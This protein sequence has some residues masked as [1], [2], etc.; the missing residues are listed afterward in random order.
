M[1]KPSPERQALVMKAVNSSPYY[2]HV[3]MAIVA[4]VETGSKLEM[5]VKQE[6]LN[7]W[8]T[9]HGGALASL[10]DSACGLATVPVLAEDEAVVTLNLQVHYLAAVKPGKLTAF[11]KVVHRGRTVIVTEAEIRDASGALVAKG[12]TTHYIKTAKV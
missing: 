4:F 12:G 7:V 11:G 6:H 10:I 5:E 3:S 1:S 2:R 8:G 9:A